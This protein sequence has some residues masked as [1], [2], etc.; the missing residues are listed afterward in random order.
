MVKRVKSKISKPNNNYN[1]WAIWAF[2]CSLLTVFI[3]PLS[4]FI[5]P[6]DSF[7][8][9]I[10]NLISPFIIV[11]LAV[12]IVLALVALKKANNYRFRLIWLSIIAMIICVY[13]F[14][15]SMGA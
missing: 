4:I 3:Y 14:T 7:V 10:I 15:I 11:F 12:S 6:F 9:S 5:V 2:V 13:P 8:F 1:W